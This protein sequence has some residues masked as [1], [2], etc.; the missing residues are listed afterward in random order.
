MKKFKNFL[1]DEFFRIENFQK[2]L[3][4]L[5]KMCFF[6]EHFAGFRKQVQKSAVMS[7][8]QGCERSVDPKSVFGSELEHGKKG[9]YANE[10]TSYLGVP[11]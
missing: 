5:T 1:V 2:R 11:K 8:R 6:L 4:S 10:R 9:K 3:I 7:Q